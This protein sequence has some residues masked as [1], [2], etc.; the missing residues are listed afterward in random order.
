MSTIPRP[1]AGRSRRVVTKHEIEEINGSTITLSHNEPVKRRRGVKG[2]P[3]VGTRFAYWDQYA[4]LNLD[5]TMAE[6][7]L[8]DFILSST[9]PDTRYAVTPPLEIAH[10]LQVRPDYISR[11]LTDLVKRRIVIRHRPSVYQVSPWIAWVGPHEEWAKAT[12]EIREPLW[13]RTEDHRVLE[14]V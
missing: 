1:V 2:A 14:L 13:S 11:I 5:V 8:V 12:A 10:R 9:S 4:M 3:R 7:R 6:R